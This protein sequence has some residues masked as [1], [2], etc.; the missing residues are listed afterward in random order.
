MQRLLLN[1]NLNYVHLLVY[2]E[3][4]HYF[5]RNQKIFYKKAVYTEQKHYF[6]R[7]IKKIFYKKAPQLCSWL[8]KAQAS[9][10]RNNAKFNFLAHAAESC[11]RDS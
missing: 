3:Q 7:E 4:K 9:H 1:E 2:T 11:D 6:E 5:E 10:R 8:W